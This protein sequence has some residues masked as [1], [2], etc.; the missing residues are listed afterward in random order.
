MH[1]IKVGLLLV[2]LLAVM[3][4][5]SWLVGWLIARLTRRS[6]F[7]VAG[8]ANGLCFCLFVGI[9]VVNLMPGEPF[10]YAATV[11]AA[12]VYAACLVSDRYWTPWA[13]R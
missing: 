8:A 12:V 4:V 5:A 7:G 6:G 3:R 2:A 10:D 13:R 1:A 11:F 9:L